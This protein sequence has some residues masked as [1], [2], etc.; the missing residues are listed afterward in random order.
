MTG[1]SVNLHFHS[2]NTS[3]TCHNDD[4]PHLHS[5]SEAA[6]L[7]GAS[8]SGGVALRSWAPGWSSWFVSTDNNYLAADIGSLEIRWYNV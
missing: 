4:R 8:V 6:V 3:P 7:G 5:L 2:T 1:T